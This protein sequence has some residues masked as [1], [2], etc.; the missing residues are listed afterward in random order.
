ML[1]ILLTLKHIFFR[2]T[3]CDTVYSLITLKIRDLISQKTDRICVEN[4]LICKKKFCELIVIS[5][6]ASVIHMQE[7]ND[8]M[9]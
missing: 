8:N 6:Q 3:Y 5:L 4:V 1:K 9:K 7:K 2:A